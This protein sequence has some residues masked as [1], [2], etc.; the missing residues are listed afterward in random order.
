MHNT[1]TVHKPHPLQWGLDRHGPSLFRPTQS[2]KYSLLH[3]THN[4][5]ITPGHGTC[6]CL[7]G[8]HPQG[9]FICLK[10][11]LYYY[12]IFFL[13]IFVIFSLKPMIINLVVSIFTNLNPE[14]R[15]RASLQSDSA[16]GSV[17]SHKAE[18]PAVQIN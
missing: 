9:A 7:I 6:P 13:L 3:P 4:S 1:I 12:L 14:C 8:P 17:H 5:R 15:G 10:F 16:V 2:C 11:S 18:P